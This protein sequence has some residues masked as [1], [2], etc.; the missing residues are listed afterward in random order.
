MLQCPLKSILL[1]PCRKRPQN[2]FDGFSFLLL[3]DRQMRDRSVNRTTLRGAVHRDEEPVRARGALS[4]EYRT[5]Q[6]EAA[7]HTPNPSNVRKDVV[8]D[9][10]MGDSSIDEFPLNMSIE[11]WASNLSAQGE[12]P[13]DICACG[14]DRTM[15]PGDVIDVDG[16]S[17]RKQCFKCSIEDC[18]KPLT[19]RDYTCHKGQIYCVQCFRKILLMRRRATQP[20]SD[21]LSD[22]S[23]QA[24]QSHQHV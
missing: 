12:T 17:Y 3:N 5:S 8:R 21:I 18:A 14:C 23:A 10:A 7:R 13:V 6:S 2:H 22:P 16:K 1:Y 11:N 4:P 15:Q 24:L 20:E 19:L 9:A